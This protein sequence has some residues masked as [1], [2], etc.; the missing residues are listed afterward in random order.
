M[1]VFII[2]QLT[3]SRLSLTLKALE[4]YGL[5]F[6]GSNIEWT[7]AGLSDKGTVNNFNAYNYVDSSFVK[8]CMDYGV[9]F[10]IIIVLAFTALMVVSSRK[11]EYL[12]VFVLL[13][14]GLHAFVDNLF[15]R[16][17]F[18]SLFFCLAYLIAP[19]SSNEVESSRAWAR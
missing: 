3:G 14:L 7:G 4:T 8:V 18:N 2:N 17:C 10:G 19:K 13:I 1:I 12:L 11:R 5:N 16:M 9:I 15:L 6:F